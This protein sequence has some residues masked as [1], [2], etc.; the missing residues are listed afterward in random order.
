MQQPSFVSSLFRQPSP[1]L[2]FGEIIILWAAFV[3]SLDGAANKAY[4]AEQKNIC[5]FQ[6][7]RLYSTCITTEA[8]TKTR[9]NSLKLSLWAKDNDST[10]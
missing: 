2:S 1:S 7:K 9:K 3:A 10:K 4:E 6:R 8:A 5:A